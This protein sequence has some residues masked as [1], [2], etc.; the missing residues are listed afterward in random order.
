MP[1][2]T[3]RQSL[4]KDEHYV[5]PHITNTPGVCGGRPVIDGSSRSMRTDPVEAAT[6][7]PLLA[8]YY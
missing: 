7:S 3:D 4:I 6:L 8:V 2:T 5:Y 1:R